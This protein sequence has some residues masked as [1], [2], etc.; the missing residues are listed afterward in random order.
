MGSMP[1]GMG[2]ILSLAQMKGNPVICRK[3]FFFGKFPDLAWVKL[4]KLINS[5]P[6]KKGY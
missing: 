1:R 3:Q 5:I 4:I 6:G 2:P